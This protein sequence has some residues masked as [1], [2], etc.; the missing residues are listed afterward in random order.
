MSPVFLLLE[1]AEASH[2]RTQRVLREQQVAVAAADASWTFVLGD[3]VGMTQEEQQRVLAVGG[4]PLSLGT[5]SLL[6]DH[7]VSLVHY[8]LDQVLG[9]SPVR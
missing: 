3:A 2:E 6:A 5:Q 9:C 8:N 1:H 4:V 7:C